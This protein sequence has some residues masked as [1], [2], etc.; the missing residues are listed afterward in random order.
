[1][2]SAWINRT[3]AFDRVRFAFLFAV[4]IAQAE[5]LLP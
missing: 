2:F 1:M 4:V 3:G 5:R